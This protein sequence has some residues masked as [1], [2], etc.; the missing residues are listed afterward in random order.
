VRGALPGMVLKQV[1]KR[2]Q[3]EREEQAVRLGKIEPSLN[4]AS[5]GLMLIESFPSARL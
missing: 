4:G 1:R 5:G 3:E 2:V